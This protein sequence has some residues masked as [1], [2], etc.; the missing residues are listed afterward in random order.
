MRY[1]PFFGSMNLKTQKMRKQMGRNVESGKYE[2]EW[3]DEPSR[4]PQVETIFPRV[5]KLLGY[6]ANHQGEI[7]KRI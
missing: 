4:K 7:S 1:K 6:H 3:Y 2:W 5:T